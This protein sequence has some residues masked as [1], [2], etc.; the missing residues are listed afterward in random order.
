MSE[1]APQMDYS[2]VERVEAFYKYPKYVNPNGTSE[3]NADG[4]TSNIVTITVPQGPN[5][6]NKWQLAWCDEVKLAAAAGTK[7]YLPTDRVSEFSNFKLSTS[8]ATIDLCN[9]DNFDIAT[10]VFTA[11]RLD[12]QNRSS[13]ERVS[14]AS[15]RIGIDPASN[16]VNDSIISGGAGR[17]HGTGASTLDEMSYSVPLPLGADGVYGAKTYFCVNLAD[18]LP[19]SIFAIDKDI[20]LSTNLTLDITIN[21]MTYIAAKKLTANANLEAN[22][23]KK[24]DPADGFRISEISLIYPVQDN[25]ELIK[26]MKQ[27]T[28]EMFV[29][30]ELIWET[31]PANTNSDVSVSKT[32]TKRINN[33]LVKSYGMIEQR[34]A[35]RAAADFCTF[36]RGNFQNLS[37]VKYN[38]CE[39]SLSNDPVL[40]LEK[41]V[42][43]FSHI[44]TLYKKKE[45]SLR[46]KSSMEAWG[47]V[48]M[49]YD[50][51][52]QHIDVYNGDAK[53][54]DLSFKD[55]EVKYDFRTTDGED[56]PTTYN[57]YIMCVVMRKLRFYDGQISLVSFEV[58]R[59]PILGTEPALV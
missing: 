19:E 45:H 23:Y 32:I 56:T 3:Y 57:L 42:Q 58:P 36:N 21:R 30:T 25:P 35:E 20:Y 15:P 17:P 26:T 34:N 51:D 47:V 44:K 55:V 54:I 37:N 14:F 49:F 11:S 12:S 4:S 24:L 6:F 22:G 27:L 52:Y 50:T 31:R 53:G 8:G 28:F 16:N 9:V 10:K 41:P 38:R 29:P 39:I 7:V 48:P 33:R 1:F 18:I 2:H 46:S 43:Y 40:R 13:P 5:N 59:A